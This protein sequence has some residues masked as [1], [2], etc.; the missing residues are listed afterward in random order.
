MIKVQ[1]CCMCVRLSTFSIVLGCTYSFLSITIVLI[2]GSFLLNYDNLMSSFYE[3]EDFDSVRIAT[4]LE[5]WK[6]VVVTILIIYI[7]LQALSFMSS[8]ALVCGTIHNRPKLI[9]SWLVIQ[10]FII[11][12]WIFA[13]FATN[14]FYMLLY[15]LLTIY[16]WVCIYSL[17]TNM[18]LHF[19]RYSDSFYGIQN[20]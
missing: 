19:Y 13:S 7:S 14:D 10:S 18:N 5:K 2:I 20:V 11:L 12:F 6:N 17:Y 8:L 1:K 9:I 16:F 3:K 4:F 15:T